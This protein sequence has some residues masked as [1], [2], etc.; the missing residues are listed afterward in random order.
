[1]TAARGPGGWWIF[2]EVDIALGS[3]DIVRP[4]LAGWRRERL[5]APGDQRPITVVPDCVCEVLSPST[6]A[7]DKVEKRQLYA[8]RGISHYW[9][10]D[11]DARTLEA[12][13]LDHGRWVLSGSYGD[14]ATAAIAPF[15]ALELEVGRLFLP[16]PETRGEGEP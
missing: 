1:M 9:M 13:E 12:F 11:V 7:R 5:V 10:V 4:D 8:D 16:K 2:V 15:E 14:D 3:H 6:A